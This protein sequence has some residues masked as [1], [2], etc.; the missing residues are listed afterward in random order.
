MKTRP[1]VMLVGL[2][3]P[4]GPGEEYV[5][6]AESLDELALLVDT[7]GGEVVARLVQSRVKPDSS[8][9]L[10]RGKLSEAENVARETGAEVLVADTEL[11]PVQLRNIEKE[12][13]AKG[14]DLRVI[15]RT[16]V[17]LEIFA[18]RA[19]SR[20]GKLQVDLA[21]AV[22]ALPRLM[23]KGLI[24]SRLGGGIGTR[25][26]GETKLEM[27]RRRLRERI[28]D[29]RRELDEIERQRVL[30]SKARRESPTPLAALVGYTNAG[31]STLFNRL[32]GAEVLV[33]DKL[34][35][36]LD[37]VIRRLELPNGQKL[38]VSDTVGFIR[39]LPHQLVAAFRATLDEV[40]EAD[41]LVHVIDASSP[42]WPSHAAAATRVLA[43]LEVLS[44]PVVY[45]LNKVDRLAGGAS[46]A[47]SSPQARDLARSAPVIALSAATGEGMAGLEAALAA[48]VA[49]RR[50]IYRFLVPYGRAGLLDTIHERG[51]VLGE[52]Y[53]AEGVEV[54]VELDTVVGSR[55]E[56]QLARSG[57]GN[58]TGG[59]VVE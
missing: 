18:R 39:R 24:L 14:I 56:S 33:E 9:Y 47:L 26:P 57:S 35:A 49:D 20:E 53:G 43:G 2:D 12:F 3:S 32:T 7:W 6:A 19:S 22:Y 36:T 11:S 10:G 27:D 59:G 51:S 31:K 17:I 42:S 8:W 38:L 37:P 5:P 58:G 44:T 29:L 52:S 46:Q 45:V 55:L 30:L 23:G 50:R 41:L 4:P 1:R 48:L 25:G 21:Q 40:R 54:E 15:D 16:Q 13:G 34:F 28:T